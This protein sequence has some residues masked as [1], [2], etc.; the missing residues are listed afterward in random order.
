M[1]MSLALAMALN[2]AAAKADPVDDARKAFNNCLINTH[3]EAVKAKKSAS[4]FNGEI[5]QAC[6]DQK[7]AYSTVLIK[8]ERSYGSSQKDAEKYA[9]EEV[10]MIIDGVTSSFGENAKDGRTL[11][12]EK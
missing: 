7:T 8:S 6:A 12:E 3:N 9:G 4:D 2:M 1:I 11:T 10:Q 5:Q